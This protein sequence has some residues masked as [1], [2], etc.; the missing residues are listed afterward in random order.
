MARVLFELERPTVGLLNIGVEEVKGLE[1]V[2]EAGQHPARGA[3]AASRICR[4]RRGRRHRQGHGRRGG[5]RRLCRQHR[6]QDRRGH[7]PPDRRTILKTRDEPH[8][9]RPGSA[10][11]LARGAFR[12]LRDKMDPRKSMAA[13][14]S[15]STASSSRATA[16]PTPKASR[17]PSIS[18]TTWCATSCSPRSARPSARACRCA[19]GPPARRE[20][21]RDRAAFGRSRLRQLSAEPR[22]HQ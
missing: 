20:P 16:A 11:C 6:A 18:A 9:A 12:A 13:S 7:G 3:T 19:T 8:A 10:I 1:E 21:H 5:D 4:L 17:P 15:A 2:R 22:P 14:S